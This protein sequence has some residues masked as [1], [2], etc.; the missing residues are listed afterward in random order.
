MDTWERLKFVAAFSGLGLVMF[1]IH[2]ITGL[3]FPETYVSKPGY[4]VAGVSEPAV[5]L[6]SLQRSWPAGLS[7]Q[8]GRANVRDYMRN[9]EKVT[10]PRSAEGPPALAAPVQQVDLATLLA[11]ADVQ[12]GRQTAQVCTSCHSFDQGQDR[13]GPSLWGV[14][15]RN[16]ASR[17]TFTYSSAFRA[18]TG[19]WTYDRLDHYLTNPAK[20][21]PGNKMGFAGLRKAEDRANVIAFLST[22]STSPVPFPKAEK[23]KVVETP[24]EPPG[25]GS[26]GSAPSSSR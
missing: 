22:L 11:A 6:G 10:V 7:E 16:V 21:V 4:K 1:G 18:Q 19:S 26:S 3:A 14:V 9:I 8:G 25:Q 23:L 2:L 24:P 12:K 5:D 13:I 17:G 20:A 15:G